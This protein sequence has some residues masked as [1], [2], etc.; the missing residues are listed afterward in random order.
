[1]CMFCRSLFVLFSFGHVLSVLL[2]FTDSDYI[3]GIFKLFFTQPR[4][5]DLCVAS[6]ESERSSIRVL[7]GPNLP[8][9]LRF[10]DYCCGYCFLCSLIKTCI[11]QPFYLSFEHFRI[12]LYIQRP[13]SDSVQQLLC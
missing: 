3:F 13:M 2:R 12:H 10:S 11:N 7:V 6:Q 4:I 8:L 9:C 1:M 5:I